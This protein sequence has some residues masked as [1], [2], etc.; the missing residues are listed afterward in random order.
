MGKSAAVHRIGCTAEM[1]P[2]PNAS[3]MELIRGGDFEAVAGS[4]PSLLLSD[5]HSGPWTLQF[6]G[7]AQDSLRP[8]HLI[9]TAE[10]L[11]DDRA[12]INS[13]TATAHGGRHSAKI[14]IPTGPAIPVHFPVPA[15][16]PS[17]TVN[18]TLRVWGRS[19]PPGLTITPK[20]GGTADAT[21]VA[22]GGATVTLGTE[23]SE[24][25]FALR[26]DG[27]ATI[28]GA[29]ATLLSLQLASPFQTGGRVWLD[30]MS[31]RCVGGT[32]A[33]PCPAS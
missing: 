31:L 26:V 10:P 12:R 17:A 15:K 29:R 32:A 30:D 4:G 23:W 16:L 9:R 6:G 19:S 18:A 33:S 25:V 3:P 27:N 20:T 13:D 2:D 22:D 5:K 21:L 14:V 1:L 24:V 11:T 8:G 28:V 7:L